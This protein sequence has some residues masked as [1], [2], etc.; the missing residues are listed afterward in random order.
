VTRGPW[1]PLLHGDLAVAARQAVLDIAADLE[2]EHGARNGSLADG[3]AGQALFFHYLARFTGEEKHAELAARSLDAAIDALATGPPMDPGL[4]S[5][6]TGVAWTA[7]HL[8]EGPADEELDDAGAEIDEAVQA[9]L[10]Q[11][12]WGE[13]YDLIRG[14]VGLGVYALE[15]LPRPAARACLGGVVTHLLELAETGPHGATWFTPPDHLGPW[16]LSVC[17]QGRYDLGVA[18]GVPAV[19]ALLADAYRL[20]LLDPAGVALL[21]AAVGWLLAQKIGHEGPCFASWIGPGIEPQAAR[22]AWCYGDAG[23]AA[24]LLHAARSAARPDWEEAALEIASRA[25]ARTIAESG[26]AD[27]GL[28]HGAFGLGHLFNRIH[29]A[30]RDDSFAA[31]AKVWYEHGL[32]LRRPG[33]GPGGF[34]VWERRADGSS[35]WIDAPGFLLGAAGIG[36]ALLAAVSDQEPL[37]D[38]L[39]LTA[40][41]P[42]DSFC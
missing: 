1:Y 3:Y 13:T 9:V 35:G 19:L 37:W 32:R 14:L 17:P 8:A 42:L 40:I 23:I 25:A 15:R 10:A 38:R 2:G 20:G 36:L 18:H 16:A 30:T 11:R 34:Q 5:G 41:P 33:Q 12:P 22:L 31:A 27:A 6:F 26:V 21:E 7:E 39:L 24:T 29:Q 4:Y 28:C